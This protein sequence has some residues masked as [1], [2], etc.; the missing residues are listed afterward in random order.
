MRRLSRR[1]KIVRLSEKDAL[2]FLRRTSRRDDLSIPLWYG[3]TGRGFLLLIQ[4]KDTKFLLQLAC[5]VDDPLD[6]TLHCEIYDIAQR[7]NLKGD[8]PMERQLIAE[9]SRSTVI[10]VRLWIRLT[11]VS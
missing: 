10:S 3:K 5:H 9:I 11:D 7:S 1:Y 6:S 4:T 8:L 2:R